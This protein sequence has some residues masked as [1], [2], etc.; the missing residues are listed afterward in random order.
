MKSTEETR[1]YVE[2]CLATFWQNIFQ[3]ET[4][5]L[6]S[7]LKGSRDILSVGCGPAMIEGKLSKLGFNVTGL[8]ISAEAL[9]CAPDGVRTFAGRAEDMPF[10]DAGFDAVIYVASLQFIEDY[11]KAL[12]R[13]VN[14]LRP[15]GKIIA[16]LL[17]PE[18]DFFKKMRLEPDSYV[19]F[20]R[21]TNLNEI[22][23]FMSELFSIQTEYILGIE[24]EKIFES[25]DPRKAVLYVING[26]KNE[27]AGMRNEP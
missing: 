10:S 22:E 4:D 25:N 16:M 24:G 6:V 14:V 8:D 26:R 5:F 11:K 2:T 9:K 17:N 18:S 20:I 12:K 27:P 7:H 13:S 21:H 15:E 3:V 1:K 19:N 23:N